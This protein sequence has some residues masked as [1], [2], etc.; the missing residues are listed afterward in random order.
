MCTRRFEPPIHAITYV[1]GRLL[2]TLFYLLIL[3]M[4]RMLCQASHPSC[5]KLIT[6][7]MMM[8]YVY[9]DGIVERSAKLNAA[10]G[11]G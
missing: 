8:T 3:L 5:L 11:G 7:M 9:C 1:H 10:H 4:L 6:V 2:G